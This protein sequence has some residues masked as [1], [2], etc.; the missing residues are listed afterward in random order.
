MSKESYRVRE[1]DNDGRPVGVLSFPADPVWDKKLRAAGAAGPAEAQRAREEALAAGAFTHVG[2][3]DECDG[4]P[5]ASLPWLL[6]QGLVER[7]E[8]DAKPRAKKEK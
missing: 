3:G 2:P 4:L 8:A 7:V 1:T 5:A 6:E